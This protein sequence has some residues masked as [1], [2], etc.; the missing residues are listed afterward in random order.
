VQREFDLNAWQMFL[1]LNWPT[2]NQGQPAP[3]LEDSYFGPP[4]WTLWH[5]SSTIFQVGGAVPAAC[6]QP[7]AMRKLVLSRDTALPVS[8]GSR[9]S[10]STPLRP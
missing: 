5:D 3:S 8:K 7:A 2:N 1:A 10:A 9:P 6:A 4:H